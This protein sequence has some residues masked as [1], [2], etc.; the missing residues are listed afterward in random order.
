MSI[1][2]IT[3]NRIY[4]KAGLFITLAFSASNLFAE[5]LKI[6]LEAGDLQE[7]KAT[8]FQLLSLIQQNAEQSNLLGVDRSVVE[9]SAQKTAMI[10][11]ESNITL[12]RGRLNNKAVDA[13]LQEAR[14][15]F[16]PKLVLSLDYQRTQNNDRT[17]NV[18]QY[19]SSTTVNDEGENVLLIEEFQDPRVPE[20]VY[21]DARDE[22]FVDADIVANA[23]SVTGASKQLTI[24]A[25]LVQQLPW[26]G[27]LNL[28]YKA[29]N[30]DTFFINNPQLLSGGT[31]VSKSLVGFG[32]YNRPW[33]SELA[34]NM[35]MPI[36]GSKGFGDYSSAKLQRTRSISAKQQATHDLRSNVSNT[37]LTADMAYWDLLES[38]LG[39]LAIQESMNAAASLSESTSRL[40]QT[41]SANNYDR[42]QTDLSLANTRAQAD[43]QWS[44]YLSA[45][46]RLSLL[47]NLESS[48]LIVPQG[49]A[50]L[51]GL[52]SAATTEDNID[53]STHSQYQSQKAASA[54]L[55]LDS[56]AGRQALMPDLQFSAGMVLR[57]SN[58]VFGYA[59]LSESLSA[60]FEPD[61]V[62]KNVGLAYNLPIANRGL[63][64]R[65]RAATA[66]L[67]QSSAALLAK[68]HLLESNLLN[69]ET[70]LLGAVSTVEF[71]TQA[72]TL[73]EQS[74]QK[75]IEKQRSRQVKE[76]ELAGLH[77]ALVSARLGH[78]SA[79]IN[80][81]RAQTQLLAAQ[82]KLPEK[83]AQRLANN[84]FERWRLA[85]LHEHGVSQMFLS[86]GQGS[87]Q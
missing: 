38:A 77:S 1:K 17:E 45:S 80:V 30:R 12:L 42:A 35:A 78:I 51:F 9:L 21:T 65:S 16:D 61:I 8:E 11:L 87:V 71:S 27:S 18:R 53:I 10:A 33:V 86:Q 73:S 48:S 58:Q 82:D 15:V 66:K 19:L 3:I 36:P 85:R 39:L 79:L 4:L 74:Y 46:D 57:Q 7:L 22:G 23:E 6:R 14:A 62:T 72:V 31:D 26:G 20:V 60:V 43:S 34:L 84:T 24:G 28:A 70:A 56:Q 29:I 37:L 81:Q 76:Y 50:D 49:F 25:G 64:A 54:I 83:Q 5:D 55:E 40:F 69:A 32:S 44:Q 67:A 13:L 68:R 52:E 63:K 59:D 41:R 2:L 75:A 47:L